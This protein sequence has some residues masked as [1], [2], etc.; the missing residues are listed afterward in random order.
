MGSIWGSFPNLFLSVLFQKEFF[1]IASIMIAFVHACFPY[2]TFVTFF[3]IQ[4]MFSG[5]FLLSSNKHIVNSQIP[6]TYLSEY[7]H[8]CTLYNDH[9]DQ[10]I[11]FPVKKLL[12]GGWVEREI[13][14]MP[15]GY[16]IFLE[17]SLKDVKE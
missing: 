11:S 4:V 8:M 10:G 17:L 3:L 1:I 9:P 5:L 2:F 7:F 13:M 14:S 15:P 12:V 6:I 16:L